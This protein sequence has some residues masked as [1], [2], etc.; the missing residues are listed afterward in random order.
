LAARWRASINS[1]SQL[2]HSFFDYPQDTMHRS[3]SVT[4]IAAVVVSICLAGC[5]STPQTKTPGVVK[6]EYSLD[7]PDG[8]RLKET[9]TEVRIVKREHTQKNVAAQVL[10]NVLMLGAGSGFQGF[11]KDGLKGSTIEDISSRENL[12]TPVTG[13]FV[14]ALEKKVNASLQSNEK[15]RGNL[16]TKP[17][18]VAGGDSRLVYESLQGNDEEQ[19]RL[20][21]SLSV[22]KVKENYFSLMPGGYMS[23]DEE[24]PEPMPQ[25]KWA[26]N[27]Y[28]L[29]KT[30]LNDQ[31][32]RCETKILAK[33]ADLLD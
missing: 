5:A 15:L 26:E 19:F 8:S 20:K 13:T 7:Y 6:V 16:Y 22:Y 24:S 31:L 21:T 33:L 29:V 30:Q 25:S 18:R 11:S 3:D 32:A 28:Q 10:L 12:R 1:A 4:G 14:T 23:C 9:P 2:I 27:D 17:L